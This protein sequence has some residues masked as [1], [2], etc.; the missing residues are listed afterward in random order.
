MD[1]NPRAKNS[2]VK[3]RLERPQSFRR[4]KLLSEPRRLTVLPVL[5]S[6]PA[7]PTQRGQALGKH[8]AWV[9]H[10][11]K[12]R[13]SA[14]RVELLE[15]HS[16][17][18]TLERIYRARRFWFQELILPE[19]PRRPAIV[20]YG[21]HDLALG[22]PQFHFREKDLKLAIPPS[23]PYACWTLGPFPLK[24][25]RTGGLWLPPVWPND[26]FPWITPTIHPKRLSPGRRML[27]SPYEHPGTFITF[28]HSHRGEG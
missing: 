1:L 15:T 24:R 20:P 18:G 2:T 25:K 19:D 28:H 11:L 21:G 16:R 3:T 14:G 17:A 5:T 22:L 9:W 10:H 8:P 7:S 4:L 26:R 13:E 6:A 27:Y 12:Q 23:G